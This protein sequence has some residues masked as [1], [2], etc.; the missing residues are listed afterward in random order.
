MN[1]IILVVVHNQQDKVKTD[2]GTSY[3]QMGHRLWRSMLAEV[4][5]VLDRYE[6]QALGNAMLPAMQKF[7]SGPDAVEQNCVWLTTV[8]SGR[9]AALQDR[10]VQLVTS[11]PYGLQK[12]ALKV[13]RVTAA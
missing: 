4:E 8:E 5:Y 7:Y 11:P 13:L 12:D 6:E 10:L 2:S 1:E 3:I 9:V